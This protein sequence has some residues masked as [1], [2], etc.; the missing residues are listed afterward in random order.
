ML[1]RSKQGIPW[2]ELLANGM[3]HPEAEGHEVYA[4]VL[5]KLLD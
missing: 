1:K 5:M 2:S 4:K 3:N